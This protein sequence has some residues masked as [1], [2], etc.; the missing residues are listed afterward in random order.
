M[1]VATIAACL[2]IA[3]VRDAAALEQ[4]DVCAAPAALG[5]LTD[6]LPK[7][8]AALAS[9][10]P[11]RIVAF[12]S[13]ST[14]G[15]G[16]SAARFNY[17]S[18]LAVDLAAH[19]P[20]ATF[21]IINRGVNG[22]DVWENMKRL[23]RDV[24]AARPDLVIWQFGT[25]AVLHDVDYDDFDRHAQQ[26]IDRMRAA[27]IEVLL[28]DLQYSPR[29]VE[30]PTHGRMLD[31]FDAIGARNHVPVFHRFAVMHHWADEMGAAY[32]TMISSDGLHMN[33]RSYACL[34]ERLAEAIVGDGPVHQGHV[35]G[36]RS[37]STGAAVH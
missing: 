28:M 14:G 22:E 2:A 13:S 3:M 27:G 9:G 17:P 30:V 5:R 11:L 23:D 15:A 32:V 24:L 20:G 37:A 7:T 16:A 33:D 10:R 18:R 21:E 4:V 6:D 36:A 1:L 12:G 25:N 26:G 35:P 8:R 29:V 19:D 34:G 31:H